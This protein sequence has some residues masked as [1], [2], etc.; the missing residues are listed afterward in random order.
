[1]PGHRVSWPKGLALREQ[2]PVALASVERDVATHYYL[3]TYRQ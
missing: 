2:Y 3:I 1:M